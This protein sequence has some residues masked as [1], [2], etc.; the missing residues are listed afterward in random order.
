[1]PNPLPLG[2]VARAIVD[3]MRDLEQADITDALAI[4]AAVGKGDSEAVLNIAERLAQRNL[5][6]FSALTFLYAN[7]HA[8]AEEA[9]MDA[10]L[11][12]KKAQT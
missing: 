7:Q 4:T 12:A 10:K 1:M 6:T 8:K 2:N 5:D 9:V 11:R 3:G